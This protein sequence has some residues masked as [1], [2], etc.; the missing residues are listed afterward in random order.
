MTQEEIEN[1]I[2]REVVRI[3]GNVCPDFKDMIGLVTGCVIWDLVIAIAPE[4]TQ[5]EHFKWTTFKFDSEEKMMEFIDD[6]EI[7]KN[8]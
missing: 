7:L 8:E 4:D 1:L 5:P 6:L 2:H 3:K